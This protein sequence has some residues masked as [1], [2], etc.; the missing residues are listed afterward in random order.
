MSSVVRCI[1]SPAWFLNSSVTSCLEK[2]FVGKTEEDALDIFTRQ[3]SWEAEQDDL[4]AGGVD[5][6]QLL[7]LVED[8]SEPWLVSQDYGTSFVQSFAD[9]E[10]PS[11][12]PLAGNSGAASIQQELIRGGQLD[13][14]KYND[15]NTTHDQYTTCS[16]LD[17]AMLEE[18][19]V[20]A[21]NT[22]TSVSTRQLLVTHDADQYDVTMEDEQSAYVT[23]P[24]NH[25]QSSYVIDSPCVNLPTTV[26]LEDLIEMLGEPVVED[27]VYLD[28]SCPESVHLAREEWTATSPSNEASSWQVQEEVLSTSCEN[29]DDSFDDDESSDDEEFVPS[30][31]TGRRALK[32]RVKRCSV[33]R[34]EYAR[35]SLSQRRERKKEQNKNAATKYREK[36]RYEEFEKETVCEKLEKRNVEL[37][38]EVAEK[39]R[40]VKLLRKLVINIFRPAESK[41][42]KATRK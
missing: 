30:V 27:H 42:G 39:E 22:E 17:T 24:M 37:K 7:P 40:E 34:E 41:K 13:E 21:N 20:L 19:G 36:K 33:R 10:T 4:F 15:D 11:A 5:G 16:W 32:K 1:D 29:S 12:P 2:D 3:N 8:L 31:S 18:L 25:D 26:E 23:D 28:S 38:K 35:L 14:G 9:P 6:W